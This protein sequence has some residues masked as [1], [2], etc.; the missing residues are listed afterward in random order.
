MAEVKSVKEEKEV[1]LSLNHPLAVIL[2]F[3][4]WAGS[5]PG[6]HGGFELQEYLFRRF[7]PELIFEVT[8]EGV[9]TVRWSRE[10]DPTMP[11][12]SKASAVES[13]FSS[14][15]IVCQNCVHYRNTKA[16]E[17]GSRLALI[18]AIATRESNPLYGRQQMLL[19]FFKQWECRRDM[20]MD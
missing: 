10:K 18:R 4:S 11:T 5:V 16:L 14:M 17:I 12:E 9:D 2:H 8:K 6:G 13:F 20:K 15:E 3:L 19:A 7:S 1:D